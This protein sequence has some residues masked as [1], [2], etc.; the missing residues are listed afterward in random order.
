MFEPWL[1]VPWM[2]GAYLLGSL[3]VGDLVA[4]TGDKSP[5]FLVGGLKDPIIGNLDRIQ[6]VKGW[7]DKNGQR[8][9]RVYNVVWSGD[10][11][12]D[13]DGKLPPVGNSVDIINANL[14]QF[15]W[16]TGTNWGMDRS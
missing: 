1:Y 15:H 12:V 11:R 14:D 4:R 10:R 2:I 7:L 6:I 3:S 5:S 16:R 9:E 8:Q 13:K